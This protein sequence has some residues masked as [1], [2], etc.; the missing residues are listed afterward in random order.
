MYG[1]RSPQYFGTV[2]SPRPVRR[3]STVG[4]TPD[5]EAEELTINES[6]HGFIV[7][8]R[9]DS[10]SSHRTGPQDEPGTREVR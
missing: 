1:I 7:P 8:S 4:Q 10:E 2:H 9:T 3:I 6:R 5:E